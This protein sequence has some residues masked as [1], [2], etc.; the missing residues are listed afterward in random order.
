[1]YRHRALSKKTY[2]LTAVPKVRHGK[3]NITLVHRFG[4][5]LA[6]LPNKYV[7]SHLKYVQSRLNAHGIV[8]TGARATTNDF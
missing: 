5:F 2:A 8:L 6:V 4:R 3:V 7:Q 1:M